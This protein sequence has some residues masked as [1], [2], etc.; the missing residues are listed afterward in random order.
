LEGLSFSKAILGMIT[1]IAIQRWF[2]K[3]IIVLFLTREFKA[4]TSNIAFWTGKWYGL[5]MHAMSQ[6]G[7]EL[8]CKMTEMGFFAADFILGHV[9]LFIMTPALLVP[10]IDK[11][12]SIMLFWLR[13]SRQIRPPIYTAKQTKLRRRRVVRFSILFFILLVVFVALVAGPLAAKKV[14]SPMVDDLGGSVPMKIMQPRP[15]KWNTTDTEWWEK[16][17]DKLTDGTNEVP[18]PM[19]GAE[20]SSDISFSGGSGGDSSSGDEDTSSS[21]EDSETRRLIRMLRL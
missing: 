1:V 13:P 8:L 21:D 6:P 17:T 5:G 2:Y 15:D 9:V 18:N 20:D 7:R 11:A 16:N 4:D 19:A 3:L 14:I 12:H 10:Y